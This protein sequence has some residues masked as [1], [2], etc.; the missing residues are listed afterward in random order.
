MARG[1]K[2][3]RNNT[4]G[5]TQGSSSIQTDQAIG[6]QQFTVADSSSTTVTT[7]IG[8]TGGVV[9]GTTS[10]VIQ[11]NYK[12]VNGYLYTDGQILS[13]RG[14]R[15]FKVQSVSSGTASMSI[16]TLT[17]VA[18]G[19]LIALQGSIKGIDASGNL[20]YASRITDKYVWNNTYK[21]PASQRFPYVLVNTAATAY[22]D[23]TSGPVV[24]NTTGGTPGVG[25]AVVEGF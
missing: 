16:V 11:I 15:Q 12:D 2:I 3:A 6:P 7:Y 8:G 21:N 14:S 25:Y 24:T 13:Q 18:P 1:L 20:F 10:P 19:S 23:T 4:Y 22:I 9:S 17:P 5:S